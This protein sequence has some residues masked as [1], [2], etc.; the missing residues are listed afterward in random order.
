MRTSLLMLYSV[1]A[2]ALYPHFV[3]ANNESGKATLSGKI[4]DKANGNTLPGVVIYIPDLKTGAVSKNDGSYFIDNLPNTKILVQ[5]SLIGYK[6][7]A[8]TVDLKNIQSKDFEMEVAVKEMNE[9]II[10]GHSHAEEKNKIPT[11]ISS[12]SQTQL[13]QNSST[14]IIDALATQPGISQISTGAGISKPVIRGLGYNRVVVVNDGIRQEGQQWG[15][16]HGL[17]IDEFSVNKVEILKG[18]ASL[19]YG[20]DAIAGV[21]NILSA[22]PLPEGAI[23]AN[24]FSNYQTNNG[25]IAYSANIAGNQKG[26]IWDLR[27]SNKI[28]HAYKNKY[29]GYVYNSG[30]REN[31]LSGMIGANK[32]WGY[33]HLNFSI[34]EMTPGI[35]EGERDSLTGSFTKPIVV[36]DSTLSDEIVSNKDLKSYT[37]SVAFQKINHYKIALNSSFVLKKGYLKTIV[38]LQQNH[39]KEFSNPFHANEYELYF[40][41]NTINYD[42]RYVYSENNF[43]ISIGANG[44]QQSSKNLGEE[45]LIPEYS[46][47]DGGVF[48]TAKKS[49]KKLTVSGGMRYDQRLQNSK[50]LFLDSKGEV[51]NVIDSAGSQKFAGFKKSF[52]GTSGSLGIAYELS[53]K[54]VAKFNIARGYRAPNIAELGSNGTHEGTLRY[55]I[56]NTNLKPEFSLQYDG[57]IGINTEHITAELSL[58]YNSLSN[59]IYLQKLANSSGQDSITD[60]NQTFEFK[61]GNANL[62]GAEISFDIHPHPFDWLH[63]ENTF[64]FV[65]AKQLNQ[66]DSTKNLP[67][68]PAP[69]LLSELRVDIKKTGKLFAGIYAKVQLENYFSQNNYFSAYTTE[70]ATPGYTLLNIGIGTDVIN[71]KEKTICSVFISANNITDVAYQ[72]HL[73]RLKY[74]SENYATGRMG[75]YNMGRNFSLKLLIP[76]N[77]KS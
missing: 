64:S 54:V 28:A 51:T 49:F 29:D 3:V 74:A 72:N 61:Q 8:E 15:D 33:T 77:I 10:T 27:Y 11:P 71:K 14:N 42:L 41:L 69:K 43:N 65:Q 67:M 40:L 13:L 9:I 39:R 6:T 26:L 24:I 5:V 35:V 1:I 44:M 4:T 25:L 19:S 38:G 75:I 22:P 68:I 66:P 12:I 21:I 63:F 36:N 45:F 23:K 57:A 52:S 59:Y 32:S 76:I 58:F 30:F 56:G 31:A 46:L 60:G 62:L 70:T 55:E 17:E 47:F 37:P 18:P 16:E 50:E 2:L 34:Y 73:S 53:E 20:S 48:I 7:I